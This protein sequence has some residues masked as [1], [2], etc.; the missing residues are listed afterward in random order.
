MQHSVS[1]YNFQAMDRKVFSVAERPC[2]CHCAGHHLALACNPCII[3]EIIVE[4]GVGAEKNYYN[5]H[6]IAEPVLREES[7]VA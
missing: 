5:S 4:I 3:V 6:G 2:W 7:I 1:E